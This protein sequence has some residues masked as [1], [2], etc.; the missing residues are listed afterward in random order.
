M[1]SH[2]LS[3]PTHTTILITGAKGQL[4]NSFKKLFDT[5][6]IG[7]I[8]TDLEEL[9]ITQKHDIERFVKDKE[10]GVIINCAAY[11]DVDKAEVEKE[12]AYRLNCHA[13]Q[14]LAEIAKKLSIV[15]VTYSTDFVFDGEK[16]S[17]YI[18]EDVPNP[19]SI[20]GKSKYDGEKAV[21]DTYNKV[22]VIRTSWLFGMGNKNFNTQVMNWAKSRKE[23]RIVD[24]QISVPTYSD[25]LAYFSWE[26][27][28]T[29]K[30]G[31]YHISNNGIA[32][33]YD[34]ANYLLKKIGWDGI[35]VRAKT[36]EFNLPAKR[37]KFSKLHSSKV[38]KIIEKKLPDWQS[39]ID[40]YL[41]ELKI[42]DN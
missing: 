22:F 27:I 25:D 37:P 30:Y 9:D 3:H 13:P 10:I 41:K 5:L 38:E 6:G 34:Q 7:Y 32:S 14:Y 1:K 26:L 33:K 42:I 17:P 16:G 18:E 15:L 28:K 24:D 21:L 40:R 36:E 2:S 8:A 35:L 29:N 19:L 4:G 39:G 11:N 12:L 20:Y 23:L 31:L